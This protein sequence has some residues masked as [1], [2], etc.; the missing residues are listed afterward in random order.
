M[1][2][3]DESDFPESFLCGYQTATLKPS[4]GRWTPTAQCRA[5]RLAKGNCSI[6]F[7]VP[8]P[9]Q[10][11]KAWTIS[12]VSICQERGPR[13]QSQTLFPMHLARALSILCVLI[14]GH[15]SADWTERLWPVLIAWT[16]GNISR[17]K[18][19][20]LSIQVS[21]KELD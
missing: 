9:S 11:N 20:P 7:P 18:Q 1:S 3:R 2:H 8:F 10:H 17:G 21:Q 13:Y 4:Q 6:A 12:L 16:T 19:P 15:P 14:L 5:Y